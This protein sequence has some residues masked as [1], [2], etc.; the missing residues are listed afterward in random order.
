MNFWHN[1]VD[2]ACQTQDAKEFPP[3][4]VIKPYKKKTTTQRTQTEWEEDNESMMLEMNEDSSHEGEDN[5]ED[6]YERAERQNLQNNNTVVRKQ[7]YK[8]LKLQWQK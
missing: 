1:K 4:A 6:E 2:K 3:V 7:K 5:Q 8:K